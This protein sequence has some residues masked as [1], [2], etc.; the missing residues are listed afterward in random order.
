MTGNAW[1]SSGDF[2]GGAVGTTASIVV[3]TYIQSVKRTEKQTRT[4]WADSILARAM[5]QGH[6]LIYDEFTR[7]SPEANTALLSVP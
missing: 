6:T 2:I 3:D 5:E 1:L 7:A 4:D